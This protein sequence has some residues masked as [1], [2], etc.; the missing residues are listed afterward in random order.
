MHY[1]DEERLFAVLWSFPSE[2][3]VALW[4]KHPLTVKCCGTAC[5]TEKIPSPFQQ[6]LFLLLFGGQRTGKFPLIALL[7]GSEI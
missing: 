5:C 2:N 3:I 4:G 1:N 7:F 6:F